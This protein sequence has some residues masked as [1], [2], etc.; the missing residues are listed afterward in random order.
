EFRRIGA[1][2]ALELDAIKKKESVVPNYGWYPYNTTTTIP[3]IA[4]LLEPSYPEVFSKLSQ[5]PV[6]DIGCGDGDLAMFFAHFGCE[7]D[8]I[9]HAESNFNQLRGIQI[10]RAQL[11]LPVNILDIDLDQAFTFPRRDYGLA[12]F[13]GTLYHL[14]NPYHV[15]EKLSNYADW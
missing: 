14:K 8:A 3:T 15:L 5:S 6:A 11:G 13:L 2:F 9:D 4:D 10:L 1:A 12:L 7:V